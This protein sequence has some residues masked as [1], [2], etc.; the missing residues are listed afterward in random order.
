MVDSDTF[1][2]CSREVAL[3]IFTLR[4]SLNLK[5]ETFRAALQGAR[6]G[7]GRCQALLRP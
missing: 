3:I 6:K 1:S 5:C 7:L 4:L 2:F